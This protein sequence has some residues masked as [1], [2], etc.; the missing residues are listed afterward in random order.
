MKTQVIQPESLFSCSFGHVAVSDALPVGNING[1]RTDNAQHIVFEDD[2]RVLIDPDSK[3][4]GILRN[5]TDK[6]LDACA[7]GE[8]LIKH[9]IRHQSKSPRHE[10][11][12]SHFMA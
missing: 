11:P 6:A 3:H 10:V 8:M 2:G 7:L 5:G 9:R 4:P 12:A 1:T